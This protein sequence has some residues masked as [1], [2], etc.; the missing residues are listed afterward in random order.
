MNPSWQG[1]FGQQQFPAFQQQQTFQQ[2]QLYLQ[3]SQNQMNFDTLNMQMQFSIFQQFLM[4]RGNPLFFQPIPMK[5]QIF[6]QFLIWRQNQR[7]NNIFN[8]NPNQNQNINPNAKPGVLP[9]INKTDEMKIGNGKY[10]INVTMNASTGYKLVMHASSDT[11]VEELLINYAKRLGLSP[12]S[13]GKDITF[14]YNGGQLKAD[15]KEKIGI[16]FRNTAVITV[17][18]LKGIIGA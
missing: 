5:S 15:C 10:I 16:M 17:Y 2:F 4:Q 18:D 13:I 12:T 8:I 14:L 11:T 9:R 3:Q 1:M 6:Q 7:Q